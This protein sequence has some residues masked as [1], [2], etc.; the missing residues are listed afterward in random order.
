MPDT[1]AAIYANVPAIECQGLCH[2]SCGPL[3][4][5]EPERAHIKA[6]TGKTVPDLQFNC[7]MLTVLKRCSVYE[8]R[9][10]LCRLWGVVESMPC[11]W[12]CRPARYLTD[13]EGHA[14]IAR[15]RSARGVPDE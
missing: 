5:E 11:E 3:V 6:R 12:G 8:D 9:P 10:L 2:Q 7:P 15:T 14:L 13:A 4:V 1:F